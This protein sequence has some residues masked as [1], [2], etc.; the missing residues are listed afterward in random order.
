MNDLIPNK[1]F[2][3]ILKPSLSCNLACEY[4]Y[5]SKMRKDVKAKMSIHEARKAVE[6]A[7]HF[8]LTFGITQVS[9]LWQGGEP[10]LVGPAYL[11]ELTTFYEDLFKRHGILC[12]SILQTNL[13][14]VN[15][16]V[17]SIV[18]QHF[19]G[20]IGF[21]YD[22]KSTTRVYPD[23]RDAAD[24]IFAKAKWCKQRGLQIGAICQITDENINH[25]RAL[26]D[27]FNSNAIHLKISQ[28]FPAQNTISRNVRF[29]PPD[30]SARAVC[31]LFDYWFDDADAKIEIS[32]LKELVVALLCS[33]SNECC[34]Q[35][36]CAPLLLS[37]VPAGRILPCARFDNMEDVIGNY[38]TDT[39]EVVMRRRRAHQVRQDYV[40]DANCVTCRF[41]MICNGGCYYNRLTGWHHGECVSNRIILS[42]IE[43]KLNACGL[44][45]G[46]MEQNRR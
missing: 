36:D 41:R 39:P 37:L 44:K 27:T 43:M 18:K 32:N 20:K 35:I 45:S 15:D 8:C 26:Y 12:S 3:F 10:L 23:G 46:C 42:H 28:V 14:L 5:A 1:S 29:L 31:E 6:W 34:R 40:V 21:S 17:V 38:Y 2:Q 25:M 4:C 9:F 16:A 22:F 30:V 13:L 33:K 19:G 24:D 11:E 7:L